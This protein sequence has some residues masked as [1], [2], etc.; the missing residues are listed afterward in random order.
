MSASNSQCVSPLSPG[1][2]TQGWV[3]LGQ[4]NPGDRSPQGWISLG[5][6][7]PKDGSP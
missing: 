2:S 1:L 6:G 3:T 4:A 5:M 7:H